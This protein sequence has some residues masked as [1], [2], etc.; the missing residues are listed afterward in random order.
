MIGNAMANPTSC[1]TTNIGTDFGAMPANV[2]VRLRAMLT[3]GFAKEVD[4]VD[5]EKWETAADVAEIR[6]REPLLPGTQP[7]ERRQH[8]AE[9]VDCARD[10]NQQGQSDNQQFGQP[11][12]VS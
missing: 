8:P 1:I 11:F 10:R 5:H 6:R 12:R 3:A 2:S 9:P 4:E 7:V